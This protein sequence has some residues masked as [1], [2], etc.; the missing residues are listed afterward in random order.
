MTLFLNFDGVL[1]PDHMLYENGCTPS[2]LSAG[3]TAFEYAS[4]LA[5]TLDGNDDVEIVLNTWWTFFVGVDS[6]LELLPP[7]IAGRVVDATLEP[8][9][10]Y[11]SF[12]C[13]CREAEKHIA[14]KNRKQLLL[15]D[16]CHARY[17][18]H[19]IPCIL[20]TDPMIGLASTAARGA[21]ARRIA[22]S[23]SP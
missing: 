15:L 18:R 5:N 19:L 3:H 9:S 1:H 10:R 6:V 23:S 14:R 11:D 8:S 7:A 16:N 21:L 20:L 22:P 12:P 4:H 2:L 13:R 17:S